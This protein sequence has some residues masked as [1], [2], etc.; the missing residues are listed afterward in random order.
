MIPFLDL[1]AI[2]AR[3]SAEISAVLSDIVRSGWFLRGGA[4]KEFE[5]SYAEFIGTR[6]CVGCAN[7]L[8]ALTLI[9][10]G[11]MALGVMAPGDEVIV[12][13]NTFIASVLAVTRCG[14]TPVMVDPVESTSL[15]DERL[16]E[17]A[18]S[19][20]TRAVMVVHLY[21]RCAWTEGIRHIC[22]RHGL[23]LIED[24]AQAHG[25]RSEQRSV[26][27][28]QMMARRTGS[29]GDAAGH[30]FYPA[31]NLGAMGD[32]GA[33][34]TDDEALADVIRR[35]GNYG[36]EPKYRCDV[37]GLNSRI[38]EMQ[39]AVLTLKLWHLDSDNARRRE[40]ADIY[41]EIL[42]RELLCPTLRAD[43]RIPEAVAGSVC[44]IFPVFTPKRDE[45]QRYLTSAGVET[46]IHYPIP[47]HRQRCFPQF[48]DMSLP[49]TERL[50]DTEL[51]LPISPVL[52]EEEA[53]FVAEAVL[54]GLEK[55]D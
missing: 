15:I 54:R 42:P 6:Y 10:K 17:A 52:T 24:N 53:R 45:L 38:D 25:A 16:I 13:G 40:V 11:Y 44:H 49:V 7:G 33:V 47:P 23:K 9:L 55:I 27:S 35:L 37:E 3:H 8:D 18:I 43:E 31:K 21:G 4:T 48:A 28:E 1:E 32:A 46:N 22:E 30:S 39:A 29:L 36:M 50:A 12:P 41:T 2:T 51:S 20:R 34:T 26:N 14:L 19:P 5:K